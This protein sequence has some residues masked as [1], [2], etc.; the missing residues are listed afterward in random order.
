MAFKRSGFDSPWLHHR[1]GL[2]SLAVYTSTP[3]YPLDAGVRLIDF[4]LPMPLATE[5]LALFC[6]ILS[7][8]PVGFVLPHRS[9]GPVGF[10][11]PNLPQCACWLCSAKH[12]MRPTWLCSVVLF[13]PV[14]FIL[15]ASSF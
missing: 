10:V 8:G 6:Q 12:T 7:H 15:L 2:F 11:L 3:V 4:V 14:V 1:Q 9:H 5:R 13:R